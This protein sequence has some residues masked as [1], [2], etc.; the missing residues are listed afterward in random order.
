[1]HI[2]LWHSLLD[3]IEQYNTIE[4]QIEI[5][6]SVKEYAM[7]KNSDNDDSCLHWN[8]TSLTIFDSVQYSP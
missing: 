2:P 7:Q 5:A 3:C 8:E 6:K 4:C 1:M